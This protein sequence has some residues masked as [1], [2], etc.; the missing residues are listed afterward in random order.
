MVCVANFRKAKN[1]LRK[2]GTAEVLAL[3]LSE[4]YIE[5][6]FG[7]RICSILVTAVQRVSGTEPSSDTV[8][9]FEPWSRMGL[10]LTIPTKGGERDYQLF[11]D[12]GES[13][14]EELDLII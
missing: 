2:G 14:L 8:I 4:L 7:C 11:L 9:A 13:I 12:E 6:G 3:P 1:I 10:G 5:A